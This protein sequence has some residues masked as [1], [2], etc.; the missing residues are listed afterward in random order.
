M[1]QLNNGVIVKVQPRGV[2]TIPREFRDQSFGEN[3]FLRVKKVS[4]RIILEPVIILD[5]PVRKY[6]DSEVD[7]FLSFDEEES[8]KLHKEKILK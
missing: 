6:S 5:Y 8:V 2:I 4:G 1:D 3:S 7:D